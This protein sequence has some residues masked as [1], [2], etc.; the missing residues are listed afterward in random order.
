MKRAVLAVLPLMLQ[1]SLLSPVAVRAQPAIF[2]RNASTLSVSNLGDE[3][4]YLQ[5]DTAVSYNLTLTTSAQVGGV[6]LPA[7][8]VI[9]GQ[10]EPVAGGLRYVATGFET[11]DRIY[12]LQ[13]VSDTLHDV[14]DPRETS[15]GA[16]L[17][18]A[19]IGAAGGAVLGGIL[20][21]GVSAGEVIGGAAAGTIIG[22]VTAQRVVVI[23][24]SQ[25]LKL[26]VQ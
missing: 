1:P 17:S 8:A 26:T 18:D 16:I 22:N 23:A 7:G 21:G 12:S 25:T 4:L 11:S 3:T 14:K 13:A 9:R 24:P 6:S 10:F 20:G 15:A 5:P 19:A 2:V